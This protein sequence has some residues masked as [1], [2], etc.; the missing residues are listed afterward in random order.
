MV[1]TW[2]KLDIHLGSPPFFSKDMCARV[3]TLVYSFKFETRATY[4][5]FADLI[6]R[7]QRYSIHILC[8]PNLSIRWW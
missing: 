6:L 7:K 4:E 1:I 8:S 5:K 2:Y 3:L